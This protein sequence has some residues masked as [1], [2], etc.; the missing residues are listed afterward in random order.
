M[1]PDPTQSEIGTEVLI[2]LSSLPPHH[3]PA[4]TSTI[5]AGSPPD[6]RHLRRHLVLLLLLLRFSVVRLVFAFSTVL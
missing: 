2:L 5:D 6:F 3:S 4:G 1:N